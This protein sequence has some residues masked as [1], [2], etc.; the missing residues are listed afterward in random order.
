MKAAWYE[1]QGA[2]AKVF[3]VGELPEP[4]PGPG[5]VKVKIRASGVNP[6]D[7]YTRSGIRRRG[8][9]FDRIVPHQDGAGVIAAV[10]DGVPKQRVGERVWLFMAQWRRPFGTAAEFCVLPTERVVKLPDNCSFTEG[11]SLG[12]PWLTAHYA[13]LCDGPVAGRTVLVAGGTG[14]VGYYA[15]QIA[16]QEGSRV[17]AT[18]GSAEKG[19]IAL[20]AGADEVI[21]FRAEDVGA[22]LPEVTKSKGADRLLEP[23]FAKNAPLFPKILAKLGTVVVYGAGGAEGVIPASWGIQNQPTIKF[24]YMYELPAQAYVRAVADFE[25]LQSAGKLKHLPV[26]EFTLDQIAQAHDA[27]EK[28]NNATRSGIVML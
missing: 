25:R 7:T 28:G 15:V 17:I 20:E 8:M 11:A 6:T 21:D 4:M 1:E 23:H 14:A 18:V 2:P 16:K 19:R 5:E 24:I 10:G 12:V 13:V 27:V 22:R 3:N 26:R 9:P